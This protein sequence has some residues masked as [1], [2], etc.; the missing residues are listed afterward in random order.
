MANVE[1]KADIVMIVVVVVMVLVTYK[2]I[3]ITKGGHQGN[4][5]SHATLLCLVC[6]CGENVTV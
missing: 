3:F 1:C 2:A 6:W 5:V 4:V